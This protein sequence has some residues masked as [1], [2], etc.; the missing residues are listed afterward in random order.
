MTEKLFWRSLFTEELESAAPKVAALIEAQRRQNRETVNLVASE[1]YAPRATI[2]AEASELVNKNATGYPPRIS[3]GG[4]RTI[5]EIEALAIN[6]AKALFGAEHANVQALSSTIANVAVLRALLR[7]GDRILAF[8]AAAGGHGSHGH[9]T[10]ISGQDYAVLHFG[11]EPVSGRVD[12]DEV[13]RLARESQPN[14]IIAGASSYP[15]ALDFAALAGIAQE[16]GAMLFADIAHVVGLVIAGLH[17][18]PVPLSD[19]VTTST[20][21]TFCGPRTGGLI[22]SR[23]THASTIDVAV[24]PGIQAAPG[25]HIIAA[26]A[27]L[28]ELTARPA[29]TALMHRVASNAAALAAGLVEAGAD[30]YA[31]GTDTH[32]IVVDLRRTHWT[33]GALME[34]L[35]EH[36]VLANATHLPRHQ[37]AASRLGLRLGT[38]AM[39]IRGMDEESFHSLGR[40]L[41]EILGGDSRV[42]RGRIK[43]W[44]R[45]F[46][47]PYDQIR[48]NAA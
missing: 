6:R 26:R 47:L 18:N 31:G 20:H 16:A 9:R 30:L 17:Q 24:S 11:V 21:K 19:V 42:A 35:E 46:P 22:L 1:S 8:S 4:G 10:H 7:P 48:P 39:T 3:F 41:G 13:R 15:R 2:V 43:E 29:F 25:A 38:T 5:D 40:E 12:Y 27:A 23:Q 28:F 36:A 14:I 33:E 37:D 32:M 34:C 45:D 44:A